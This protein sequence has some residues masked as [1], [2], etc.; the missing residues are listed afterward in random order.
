[1]QYL[2]AERNW[3]GCEEVIPLYDGKKKAAKVLV[4][5]S[6]AYRAQQVSS[7]QP[8]LWTEPIFIFEN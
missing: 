7:Q 2:E 5:E 1:M 8:S 6:E 4:D 3:N